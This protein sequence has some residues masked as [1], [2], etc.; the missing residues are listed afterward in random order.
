[1]SE[2]NASQKYGLQSPKPGEEPSQPENSK[3]A[4][5]MVAQIQSMDHREDTKTAVPETNP[6]PLIGQRTGVPRKPDV[7]SLENSIDF[8][9]HPRE[10]D[11]SLALDEPKIPMPN[12]GRDSDE[13]QYLNSE[14]RHESQIEV[15]QLNDR[16]D[17]FFEDGA[18][19]RV[20]GKI[21]M[22]MPKTT[23]S[24][25][26]KMSIARLQE[27]DDGASGVDLSNTLELRNEME[28]L[29]KFN[30]IFEV[31]DKVIKFDRRS[32]YMFSDT[33]LLRVACVWLQAWHIFDKFII[34]CILG[35]SFLLASKDYSTSYDDNVDTSWND[36]LASADFVFTIIFIF[37]CVVRIV[38]QGFVFHKNAYLRNGW[39]VL[40]F[41]IVMISVFS[42]VSD[43]GSQLK[44]LRTMRVLRPLRTISSLPA[45]RKL[46][47]TFF[48]SIPGLLNV[49]IFLTFF[50][51]I[52]AIFG[53]V[54][55]TGSQYNF[56]RETLELVEPA[57]GSLPYWPIYEDAW[58]CSSDA[59]C[60]AMLPPGSV[61]KCGNIYDEY[62]LD[63]MVYDN[64]GEMGLVNFDVVS[65]NNVGRA[66][67][68]IFQV[69][70]ME[71]WADLMYNFMDCFSPLVSTIF[72]IL[73]IIF[74][75]FVSMNLFLAQ[76]MHSFI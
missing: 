24:K 7:L 74:G 68:M 75:A 1:M 40:D 48:K 38:A 62:G 76:I 27:S 49:C 46:I 35:N 71:G 56:C 66:G 2:E 25:A 47:M 61:A 22:K 52:F 43:S 23:I 58:L 57:D 20:E 29:R 69:L 14:H 45:M 28:L 55:F 21:Q 63:P 51:A 39:N 72:F 73:V 9:G 42:M 19:S 10:D 16:E 64:T 17:S 8:N 31:H 11:R 33:N 59:D 70:T 6:R 3:F 18:E 32:V 13:N 50:F 12:S 26:K 67:L 30:G 65:F 53:V 44:I 37:E 54:T 5:Q 41:F 60:A 36:V 15:A 34:I 4:I